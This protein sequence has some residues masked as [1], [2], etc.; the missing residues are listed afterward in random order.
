M[1]GLSTVYKFE[2]MTLI[3]VAFHS[4]SSIQLTI[5]TVIA[6]LHGI[7]LCVNKPFLESI[8]FTISIFNESIIG[9]LVIVLFYMKTVEEAKQ[10]LRLVLGKFLIF[11][12]LL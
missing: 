4:Y 12:L 9:F 7:E 5:I 2:A 11:S 6:I 3:V 10:D 8:K 1:Y